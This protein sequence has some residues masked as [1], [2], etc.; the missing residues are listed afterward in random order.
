M[1][2]KIIC[3][4]NGTVKPLGFW[5]EGDRKNI[6]GSKQEITEA[7]RK[8]HNVHLCNLYAFPVV[9]KLNDEVGGMAYVWANIINHLRC[10]S[11]GQ[12]PCYVLSIWV[13]LSAQIFLVFL[14][15]V[16]TDSC[17]VGLPDNMPRLFLLNPHQFI[18]CSLL[19]LNPHKEG[20]LNIAVK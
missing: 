10:Q 2:V 11:T 13:Q 15:G 8:L 16:Y 4:T 17:I 14:K 5:E 9:I 6:W 19:T 18:N 20:V 12:H 3:R 7:G 1:S